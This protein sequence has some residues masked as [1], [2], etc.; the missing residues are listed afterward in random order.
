MLQDSTK[1]RAPVTF[2]YLYF[3]TVAL[4]LTEDSSG[5]I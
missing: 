2:R 4:S 3:Q 1:R 5:I